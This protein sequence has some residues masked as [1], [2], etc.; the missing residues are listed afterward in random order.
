MKAEFTSRDGGC[1][2]EDLTQLQNILEENHVTDINI[3]KYAVEYAAEQN[4]LRNRVQC[5]LY[6]N[7]LNRLE[8]D[9]FVIFGAGNVAQIIYSDWE[10]KAYIQNAFLV[11]GPKKER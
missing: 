11:T 2:Y 4:C 6:E 5:R 1:L 3:L 10:I 8:S 7:Q 9:H